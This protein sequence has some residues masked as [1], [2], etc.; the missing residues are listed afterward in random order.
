M[1]KKWPVIA[2]NS[3]YVPSL[4]ILVAFFIFETGKLNNAYS[5]GTHTLLSI[6]AILLFFCRVFST[7]FYH[8]QRKFDS[9]HW[10][11]FSTEILFLAAQFLFGYLALL[12]VTKDNYPDDFVQYLI[13]ANIL[14]VASIFLIE[15]KF[16]SKALLISLLFY[17]GFYGLL[18]FKVFTSSPPVE[19]RFVLI[20]S[21]IIALSEAGLLFTTLRRILR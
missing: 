19:L 16:I 4:I 5:Q 2:T 20:V 14:G 7:S 17:V 3:F 1:F 10:I 13:I 21:G 15:S 8:L 9:K 6:A 12:H 11:S 18:F